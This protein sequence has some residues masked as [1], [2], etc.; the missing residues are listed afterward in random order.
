VAHFLADSRAPST[1][2]TSLF[3]LCTGYNDAVALRKTP[4]ATAAGLVALAQRLKDAGAARILVCAPYSLTRV[5]RSYTGAGL[6]DDELEHLSF[7]GSLLPGLLRAA[8]LKSR[9]FAV[10]DLHALFG[11]LMI[12]T[13][14][15]SA[16]YLEMVTA[17]E[18]AED[19]LFETEWRPSGRAE[20]LMADEV[21][22]VFQAFPQER[23]AVK[24]PAPVRSNSKEFLSLPIEVIRRPGSP[25]LRNA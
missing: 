15:R 2:G 1:L 20:C 18:D 13:G 16:Q 12:P 22:E 5:P 24:T 10:V 6:D 14:G 7:Y 8:S 4:E 17:R 25:G 9:A 23:L 11:R 21:V 3:L 19:A